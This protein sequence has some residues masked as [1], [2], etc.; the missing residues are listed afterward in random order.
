VTVLS[1]ESVLPDL[2]LFTLKVDSVVWM[3]S[4]ITSIS[5]WTNYMSLYVPDK[6]ANAP[7]AQGLLYITGNN[8]GEGPPP[9]SGP[10]VEEDLVRG[11]AHKTGLISAVLYQIPN[12]P[13]I[14]YAEGDN[15][16]RSEDAVIAYT[17]AKFM[18]LTR[19]GKTTDP[20]TGM[21][22]A[23][24]LLRFPMVKAAV[25][26]IDAMQDVI[27]QE[28]SSPVPTKFLVAGASKR[29][30]T[31]WLTPVVDERVVAIMPMVMPILNMVPSMEHH[32]RAYNNWSFA[33]KDYLEEDC[34]R[35]LASPEMAALAKLVDPYHYLE[36][37]KGLPKYVL[38]SAGDE[39]FLPD[40]PRFFWDSLPGPKLLNVLAN[41]EHSLMEALPD[42]FFSLQGFAHLVQ[43]QKPLPTVTWELTYANV[44]EASITVTTDTTPSAVT[45]WDATTLQSVTRDFRLVT[46]WDITKCLQP[47][48][49]TDYKTYTGSDGKYTTSMA[50][51]L[52]GAWAGF[53]FQ[54][55]FT[56][57]TFTLYATSEV[58]IVPDRMPFPYP[59]NMT[60]ALP[61]EL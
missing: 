14:F 10:P 48:I 46:C 20:D 28:T 59:T 2:T 35:Y 5:K 51:P 37:L 38:T 58:N 25:R 49:W 23:D 33:L 42:I 22:T 52:N 40:S 9:Y 56:F 4:N 16:K 29:G 15:H 60:V 21:P 54:L 7:G 57:D 17:W 19:E 24:W 3:P 30:W 50:P 12:Q 53:L 18:N 8:N 11:A 61:D 27:G 6:V 31:T 55:Q 39:F 43:Y 44:S 45:V 34:M 1:K 47:V 36:Q 41:A 13:A 32:Y 26:A